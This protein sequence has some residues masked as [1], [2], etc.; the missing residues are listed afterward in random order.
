LDNIEIIVIDDKSN[1]E[2][3]QYNKLTEE[4]KVTNIH[5]FKNSKEKRDRFC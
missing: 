4:F 2:L 5:F 3:S 1:K